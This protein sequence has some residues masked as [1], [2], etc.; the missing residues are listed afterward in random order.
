MRKKQVCANW[1]TRT[2]LETICNGREKLAQILCNKRKIRNGWTKSSMGMK[3]GLFSMP[4]KQ[5][6]TA[7]NGNLQAHSAPINAGMKIKSQENVNTIRWLPNYK[8]A[9]VCPTLSDCQSEVSYQSFGTSETEGP[10]YEAELFPHMWILPRDNPL[11][12]K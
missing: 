8:A 11:S 5:S 12:H 2:S 6:G 10:S 9:S 3:A 1:Y 7:W 4:L